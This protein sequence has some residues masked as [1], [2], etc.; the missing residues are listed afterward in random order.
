MIGDKLTI[1]QFHIDAARGVA[2]LLAPKIL[3]G[4]GRR[5]ITVAGESGAGKSEIAFVLSERLAELGVRCVILQQDDYFVYPPKT[6]AL[7][8]R[9]DINHVGP[10]E[11]RLDLIDDNLREVLEGAST[12]EKPLVVYEEDRVTSERLSLDEVKAVIVEGTYVTSLKNA[13][14]RVFIDRTF[15]ETAAARKERAR[16]EQDPHLEQVLEI[17]HG[18]ISKHKDKADIIVSAE[19]K[20]RMGGAVGG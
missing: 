4:E 5:V 17:E 14:Y 2:G 6:N 1:K 12:I 19:Y 7:M 10:S 20:V 9:R 8:R 15:R 3:G 18:V 16:E 13:H 11:V